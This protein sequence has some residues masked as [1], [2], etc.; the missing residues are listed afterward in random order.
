MKRISIILLAGIGCF[1]ACSMEYDDIDHD[2]MGVSENPSVGKAYAGEI[3]QADIDEMREMM[4]KAWG[5]K[6]YIFPRG[7]FCWDASSIRLSYNATVT[8]LSSLQL[9]VI[10]QGSWEG[11]SDMDGSLSLSKE[12]AYIWDLFCSDYNRAIDREIDRLLADGS[13]WEKYQELSSYFE[14]RK[15]QENQRLGATKPY[16]SNYSLRIIQSIRITSSSGLYGL[17]AGEDIGSHFV[18]SGRV[19]YPSHE[20]YTFDGQFERIDKPI[21]GMSFEEFLEYRP[22]M[23]QLEIKLKDLPEENPDNLTLT[24][25]ITY[26]DGDEVSDSASIRIQ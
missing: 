14:K 4:N 9:S 20:W 2:S 15:K 25:S 21:D 3:S 6:S 23:R 1:L 26:E 8:D 17:E 12:A 16:E 24:V 10:L 22:H 13:F 7:I 5:W 19:D 11:Y 18:L